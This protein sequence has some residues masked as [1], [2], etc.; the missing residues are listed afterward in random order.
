MFGRERRPTPLGAAF[1][2]YGRIAKTEHLLRVVDPV[3]NAIVLR[4]TKSIDAAVEQLRAEGHDL[5]EEDIARLSPL[6]HRNLNLL[7]RCGFTASAPAACARC[8][9]R[10]RP[11]WTRTAKA[12]TAR[13]HRVTRA[14]QVPGC[15][16]ITSAGRG[17]DAGLPGMSN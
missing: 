2:K 17:A 9:T 6:K 13:P 1:A 12:W 10:T 14:Y 3:L 8:A 16:E 11:C 4:T 5:R 15:S 7:G